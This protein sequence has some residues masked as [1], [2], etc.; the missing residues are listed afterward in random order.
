[1]FGMD[2]PEGKY[3]LQDFPKDVSIKFNDKILGLV[4]EM[5]KD[6]AILKEAKFVMNLK[7]QPK[8]IWFAL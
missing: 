6:I 5:H 8:K 1:M 3:G 4:S 7:N 2:C